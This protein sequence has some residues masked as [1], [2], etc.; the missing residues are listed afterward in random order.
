MNRLPL[1]VRMRVLARSLL[2][3]GSWNYETLIGTGF[4]FTILPALR[5]LSNGD[6]QA[7]AERVGRHAEL[8]NS[9]PYLAPVAAG[10]VTR[11]EADGADP[12]LVHRFKSALRGSLGSIGDQLVWSAW[13]PAS[14]LL[15]LCLLLLGLAW[16][17][18]V[19]AFL[20]VYNTLHLG[21]RV[22]GLGVGLER[23]LEVGKALREA[24]LQRIAGRTA[25][26]G[27]VLAGLAAALAV[28]ASGTDPYIVGAGVVGVG[29]GLLLGLRTYR[30]AALALGVV[31]S[32]GIILGLRI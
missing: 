1:A 17:A 4:A 13:R 5:H 15:G 9:H 25:D 7:L 11:L 18:A 30:A 29:A 2:V 14:L 27:A 31:W 24:P 20:L 19:G 10:A 32:I 3:Q 8:F 23:G 21:L 12:L 22:W 26:V 6:D 16:W 28:G